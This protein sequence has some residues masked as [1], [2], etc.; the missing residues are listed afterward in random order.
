MNEE[1]ICPV[2]GIKQINGNFYYSHELNTK[3][4]PRSASNDE[5][6]SKICINAKK[7]GCIN[8]KGELNP[9]QTW[10]ALTEQFMSNLFTQT[11]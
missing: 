5:V 3:T 6:Y 9:D 10:E 4:N 7:P 2:C 11:L 8:T 1:K